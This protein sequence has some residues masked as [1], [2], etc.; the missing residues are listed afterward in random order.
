M[1]TLAT[2]IN[3]LPKTIML[4]HWRSFTSIFVRQECAII[5]RDITYYYVA[6]ITKNRY[7][8]FFILLQKHFIR[9]L[10]NASCF[11][12]FTVLPLA[13]VMTIL[14]RNGIWLGQLT[15]NHCNH[16][17]ISMIEVAFSYRSPC[18][19]A[20]VLFLNNRYTD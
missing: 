19:K 3:A 18:T 6:N 5:F 20:I 7:P 13:Y 2:A 9:L 12:A 17:R 1:T 10:S 16:F 11:M 8:L 15:N 14:G 4:I